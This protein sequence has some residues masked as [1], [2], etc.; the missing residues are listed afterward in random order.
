MNNE[1]GPNHG[2]ASHVYAGYADGTIKK[3][4]VSSG[5][6]TLQI[7]KQTKKDKFGTSLIWKLR[8]FN[9]YLISGD[10]KGEVCIWDDKFGTLFKKFNNLSAD[11]LALEVNQKYNCVYATGVDS[12]VLNI[13]MT[14]DD[15]TKA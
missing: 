3:W 13:Q 15:E 4:E 9:G 8:L 12:R 1:E 5:N 14:V 2:G 7:D 6:C 11:V 10:S